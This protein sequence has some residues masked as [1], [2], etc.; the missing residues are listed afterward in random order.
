MFY[1]LLL[2]LSRSLPVFILWLAFVL[3][4]LLRTQVELNA[5]IKDP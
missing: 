2:F 4:R 3:L 5:I 1:V